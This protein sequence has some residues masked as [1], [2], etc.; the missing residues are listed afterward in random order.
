MSRLSSSILVALTLASIAGCRREPE[1]RTEPGMGPAVV[2]DGYGEKVKGDAGGVQSVS[3]EDGPGMQV[4]RV[5][6]L[7]E[8]RF[9][10][11]EVRRTADGNYSMM[12]RGV[13][14]FMASE[15][16]LF[17]IDGAPFQGSLGWLNPADV[18]RIDLLKNP[19]ETAIY[20]LRGSNG[21][22]VIT[23]RRKR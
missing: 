4:A 13:G 20:G 16:P 8:A 14:S 7:I 5:E 1:F 10:G 3:F 11:V 9:P 15:Q 17:V 2:S 6:Q 12:I 18:M 19:T 22:F 23:T 21:V